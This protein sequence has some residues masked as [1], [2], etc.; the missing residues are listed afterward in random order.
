MNRISVKFILGVFC[1][2]FLF[3]SNTYLVKANDEKNQYINNSILQTFYNNKESVYILD[4][5]GEDVTDQFWNDTELLYLTKDWNRI[6]DYI[7]TNNLV[8]HKV[9]ENKIV[10]DTRAL[11]QY[12]TVVSE[13]F[14]FILWDSNHATNMECSAELKGGIWYDVAT[15][16]VKRV[17]NT[18]LNILEMGTN[19]IGVSLYTNDIQT[20][21]SVVDGKG[22][23]WANCH[24]YGE[25]DDPIYKFYYDYG[26][27]SLSFYATP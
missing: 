19:A 15:D 23:F 3:V 21:S 27:K 11:N 17:S 10:S 22:Y 24:F 9:L 18:T 2:V 5:M 12:K 7:L 4:E 20:S 25:N 1:S 16:E 26:S 13:M 14:Y 6:K 8:L